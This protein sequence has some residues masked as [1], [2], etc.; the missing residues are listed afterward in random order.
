MGRLNAVHHDD[1]FHFIIKFKNIIMPTKRKGAE[2]EASVSLLNTFENCGDLVTKIEG[3][4]GILM[5][6]NI[7][8]RLKQKAV[9]KLKDVCDTLNDI[10]HNCP[11]NAVYA[12]STP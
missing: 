1:I 2:L 4:H 8:G 12:S 5:S 10:K 6:E 11:E 3:V 9:K 7:S